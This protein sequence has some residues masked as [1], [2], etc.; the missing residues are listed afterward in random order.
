M[1]TPFRKAS[2]LHDELVGTVAADFPDSLRSL[3]RIAGLGEDWIV[4]ALEL[5]GSYRASWGA[6]LAVPMPPEGR[7]VDWAT[8]AARHGG[9]LPVRRVALPI[10]DLNAQV[11][12]GLGLLS[13]LKRWSV[14][15][16]VPGVKD[17]PLMPLTEE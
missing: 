3:H 1:T 4:V 11:P 16:I 9:T 8:V 6:V 15:L 7:W 5:D 13:E 12:L 17:I 14:R 10:Q 2:V